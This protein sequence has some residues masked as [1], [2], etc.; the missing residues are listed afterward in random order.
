MGFNV[1]VEGDLGDDFG[2]CHCAAPAPAGLAKM[3]SVPK[4]KPVLAG[5]R[6]ILKEGDQSTPHGNFSDPKLSPELPY[7]P[8]CQHATVVGNTI[9]N[10]LINGL[11]IAHTGLPDSISGSFLTCTHDIVGPGCPTVIVSDNT[12]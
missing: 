5:G 11:P 4:G 3:I 10:I 8:N 7:N 9:P 1:A 2:Y 6:Q 12:V